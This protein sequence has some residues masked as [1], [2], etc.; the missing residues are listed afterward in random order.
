MKPKK[1]FGIIGIILCVLLLSLAAFRIITWTIFWIG[2]ITLAAF[3]YW[4][5]P[6]MKN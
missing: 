3:A 5:L 2:I 6:K 4:I 1:I